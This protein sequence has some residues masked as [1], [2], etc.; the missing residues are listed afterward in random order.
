MRATLP[1]ATTKLSNGLLWAALHQR[2]SVKKIILRLN[3]IK[4]RAT[5]GEASSPIEPHIMDALR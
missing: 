5:S 4:N 2:L 1:D 3:A